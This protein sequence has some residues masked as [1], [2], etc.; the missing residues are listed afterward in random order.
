[1][2][3]YIQA[4]NGKINVI[5]INK[6]LGIIITCGDDNYIL[7]RKLYDFELLSP[8]KIKPKYI[9]TMARVSPLNF[10][11]IIFCLCFEPL[12][13]M[14]KIEQDKDSYIKKIEDH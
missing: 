13:I 9:I 11:Y 12:V 8:I 6:K 1:M 7:I 14:L 10:L 4:H 3:R 5:E 2:E